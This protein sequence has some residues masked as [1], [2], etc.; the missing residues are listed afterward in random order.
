M[1]TTGYIGILVSD[2]L[3]RTIPTNRTGEEQLSFYEEACSS[4]GL[5]PCYLRIRNLTVGSPYVWAYVW[6]KGHYVKKYVPYPRVFHNRVIF[7]SRQ[8]ALT[9]DR[10]VR[11][12]YAVFNR[13][14]RYSKLEI[15]RLLMLDQELQPHLPLT[16]AGTVP[17]IQQMRKEFTSLVI[18]PVR[19]SVGKGIMR[20]Q[21]QEDGRW[22]LQYPK[23][24]S[25]GWG[26][27]RFSKR[28]PG[29]LISR[30]RAR[31]YLV[32]HLLPLARYQGSPFDI[33]VSVQRNE[34]GEWQ[35]TGMV[36]KVA[37][38]GAFLTNVAQGGQAC[39]LKVLLEGYPQLDAEAVTAGIAS[40]ALRI[41][42]HLS[43]HLP[44]LADLGLDIGI[45][46]D[47]HPVFIEANGRDQRYSFREAG[48]L[49]EWK[50]TYRNPMA[51]AHFLSSMNKTP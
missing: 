23:T 16:E 33:R 9:I 51:Y 19:G 18:K 2:K 21:L 7:R 26:R 42:G 10:L 50:A 46:E 37:K 14:N 11:S 47:G 22:E 12:G 8:S 17:L 41:A 5:K 31:P 20:L 13:N 36:G 34:T 24:T 40:L 44:D 35:V 28:L 4:F 49:E 1:G 6:E 38:Q 3:Y 39:P 48:M 25:K 32:Q 30:L 29:I 27:I 15:H 43:L 45:M